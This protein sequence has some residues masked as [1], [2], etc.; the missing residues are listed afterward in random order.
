L[1]LIA[2][3]G[4]HGSGKSTAAKQIAELFDFEYL[5]AGELFRSIAREKE[6]S[7]KELSIIAEKNEDIDRIIDNKTL[8]VAE[9][10][11]DLVVDAQLAG[12]LLKDK[13]DLLIY[14]TAPF[15]TRVKRIAQR[16]KKT[17]ESVREETEIREQSEKLRYQK[18]Y[19]IDIS[20]LSIYD[21]IINTEKFDPDDCVQIIVTAIKKVVKR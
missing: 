16:D 3:S 18:L 21:I 1:V 20:D 2:I 10:E 13:A 11:E 4:P 9:K 12:W 5:S 6:L 7:L 8:E 15:Q 19:K 17:I 14:I